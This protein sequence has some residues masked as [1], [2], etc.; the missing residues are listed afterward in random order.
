M[1]KKRIWDPCVYHRGDHA[2][3]FLKQYLSQ[4]DRKV[5]LIAGAGFDPRSTRIADAFP[6]VARTRTLAI[7]L[8]EERPNPDAGLVELAEIGRASCRERVSS[9]V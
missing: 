4:P 1:I 8:R 3:Q 7:F 9:V 2:E 5:L 6:A